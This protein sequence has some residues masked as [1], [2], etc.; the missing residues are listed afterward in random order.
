MWCSCSHISPQHPHWLGVKINMRNDWVKHYLMA[1]SNQ[2]TSVMVSLYTNI[3]KHRGHKRPDTK[4]L[5]SRAD[6]AITISPIMWASTLRFTKHQ[7]RKNGTSY[8]WV[9]G[10]QLLSCH[11]PTLQW[12]VKL[13]SSF[14]IEVT[15]MFSSWN[16]D[17]S[18]SHIKY[19]LQT[20]NKD[21][22]IQEIFLSSLERIWE[23]LRN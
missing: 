19:Y 7:H 6:Y 2:R 12:S 9:L 4:S 5:L 8:T 14:W 15:H 1:A 11:N 3:L 21:L 18:F 22:R 23:V 17:L 16:M 13:R 10:P 20:L